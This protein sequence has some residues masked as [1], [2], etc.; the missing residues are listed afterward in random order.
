MKL[1]CFVL[2]RSL[3]WN[4]LV[5]LLCSVISF[6]YKGDLVSVQKAEV[7]WVLAH[8]EVDSDRPKVE[9]P[10]SEATATNRTG[11]IGKCL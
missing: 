2:V 10:Q 8:E 5:C 9:A 6:F 7:E 4:C 3:V 1:Y 11:E